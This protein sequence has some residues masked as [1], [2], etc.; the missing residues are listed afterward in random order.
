M[1]QFIGEDNIYFYA[2]AEMGLF[3][4]LDQ[5]AGREAGAHLPTT[6]PNRHAFFANKKASSSSA[7]KPPKAMDLLDH[8]TPEQL[9]MHFA[10]MALQSNSVSFNPKAFMENQNGFDA[11]LAEGNILTNVYNRLIR[12][13]FY[14]MQKYFEGKLPEGAVSEEAKKTADEMV[15]EYEWAMYKFE[16]SRVIDLIDV[17]LRDANKLWAEK[18][19]EAEREGD[20][21]LR[22]QILLDTFHVVRTAATLLHPFAPMGTDMVREYLGFDE[23][24]WDWTYIHEPLPFFM[25]SGHAFKFLEP[26]VDFFTKHTAQLS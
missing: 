24:L 21:A 17:Y 26:R 9:R 25:E 11:T 4:A 7:V 10:H 18:S 1:Y 14:T 5:I 13:C 19:K 20:E 16:F 3:M 6:I 22:A 15:S 12:S 8:Y 2:I 23:R